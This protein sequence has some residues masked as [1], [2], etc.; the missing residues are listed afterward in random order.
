MTALTLPLKVDLKHVHLSDEQ[1][2]QLCI[3]NPDLNIERSAIGV[4]IFMA[5]V[6]GDSGNREADFIY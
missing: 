2:Y 4:L 1:F 6:G 3:S 5:P